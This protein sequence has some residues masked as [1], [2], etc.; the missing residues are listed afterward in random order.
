MH[1]QLNYDILNLIY[2]YADITNYWKRR[3]TNDILPLIDKGYR[4]VYDMCW[5]CY[6]YGCPCLN[7]CSENFQIID[8]ITYAIDTKVRYSN[9]HEYRNYETYFVCRYDIHNE[10][11]KKINLIL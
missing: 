11:I 6:H 2:D 1:Y 4:P 10:L 9:Y 5:N 8:Y 3:L 7:G